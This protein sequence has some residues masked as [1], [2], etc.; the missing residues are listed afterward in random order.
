MREPTVRE[1]VV[2]V[3]L[4]N[5]KGAEDTITCLKSF[6]DVEW[7]AE[8]LELIVVDNDSQDGSMERIAAAVPHAKV[9]QSG[10]NLGFAG[11]CNL[12]VE[13][14]TGQWVAF[15]NNDARPGPTWISAAVAAMSADDTIGAVASK[16]LDWEGNLIDYVDGSLTWYGM[17]YKREAEWPDS[18][19]Y[20]TPKDVLFG[21]GAAMF[22][23]ATLYREI[24]GFDE[25]FFMFYE[26]V[27]LGW[28]L[29]LLGYRVRYVPESL[30]YHRHHVTMKKFGN[31]RE[32]Y[33]LERNALLSM[34]KNLDDESLA[35]ALPAAM[36]LSVRRSLA[37]TGTD[38]SSLD[39]QRSPGGDDVPTVEIEKMALT[40]PYAID[41][42]VD[43]LPSLVE[44][45]K[46]LQAKRR[47]SD[48]ELFP[49][50][51]HAIEPAY[52]IESYLTAHKDLVEAFGIDTH[53]VS[54]QRI[55]VVTGEPLL[56]RMA[57]PAIRAWE[58][59][60]ALAPIADVRL[61][62]TAGARIT[63]EDFDVV[64]ASGRSL[65]AQTDWADV[66][67]F[68]GF[69]LE[70]APWLKESS[71]ILVAD[72]Y[73]PMHL[74]QLE[75]ARDLGPA[76]RA[77][78][79]RDT[80][81]VLNEQLRRAD[82]V[83]CASTKQRD[84]WLGQLAGQGRINA[85][86]Y[87]EDESLDSLIGVVPFGI[88]DDK[89]VQHKHA[90]KGTVPGIGPDDKVILWGGGVYNW[91]DPLTLVRAVDRLRVA[92]PEVRLYFLG[93]KHPNPGVP[94]MR[95]AWELKE[96]SDELGLTGTHVF[97]N[98]GWVPYNE[99]AD[100]LLDA[101]LGV[102]THFHHVETAYS[103]RTRIL[104]YLWASLPIVA[105]S[106]DTFG[107]LIAE[108]GL[109][110]VVPPEDPEA[111]EAALEKYLFD[112]AAIAEARTNVIAF[113]ED[114]RWSS[115]LKPLVDFCRFPRRAADLA[116]ELDDPVQVAEQFRRPGGLKADIG[117]ARDYLRAG[118]ITEVARRAR[119]R[120]RRVI[121]SGA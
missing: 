41:Y 60:K 62:S 59:A 17:G 115:V 34:Y 4:V 5:Y 104:D 20:D 96:L 105:T 83:L 79:I 31:Y 121:G 71:K 66:I 42:F 114:Y 103:F 68:Q 13:H 112:D 26:D 91:F 45:R 6:D 98:E 52:A 76:G 37:R 61:L 21:T 95:I 58:I 2:S 116:V 54:R 110:A 50:F 32:S 10:G 30:A 108:R 53:F 88:S 43:Q 81:R 36:A 12:G 73:D 101:D 102:S 94:D 67:V 8:N 87:D 1:G 92:H 77:T 48:R 70:G 16:V 15:I 69:L 39:L 82:Y 117:L 27:D 57:G 113:A 18:S 55:L 29:N 106:G 56:E 84:F 120:V 9:I 24:G 11:G 93:L 14:A 80:T 38:A 86:V 23:P 75:Q 3:I 35:R 90:I 107:T 72:V 118:G 33:L 111:L 78:S 109:G 97:F 40:G 64:H 100:Y 89:P 28:R 63:S 22:V 49:L 19:D 47:R 46:E 25:R 65:R 119:G 74:E 7:P 44:S 51:R 99:R 85:A